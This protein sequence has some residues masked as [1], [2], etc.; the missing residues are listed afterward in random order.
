MKIFLVKTTILTVVVTLFCVLAFIGGPVKIIASQ[1]LSYDKPAAV[2]GIE[3]YE[4]NEDDKAIPELKKAL[5]GTFSSVTSNEIA[6]SDEA[7]LRSLF[8]SESKA[9][10]ARYM[11]AMN[12]DQGRGE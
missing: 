6:T 2:E 11:L 10:A 12:A 5:A 8:D 4:N 7:K 3:H 9:A 1:Q